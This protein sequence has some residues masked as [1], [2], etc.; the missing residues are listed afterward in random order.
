VS[1]LIAVLVASFFPIGFF[2]GALSHLLLKLFFGA[3]FRH[4]SEVHLEEDAL[5]RI[6]LLLGVEG[7]SNRAWEYYASA[8]F[9]HGIIAQREPGVHEWIARYWSGFQM[10]SHSAVALWLAHIAACI[11]NSQEGF[12]RSHYIRQSCG[13]WWLTLFMSSILITNAVISWVRCTRM[14]EFQSSRPEY[15]NPRP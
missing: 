10:S 2:I 9:D 15:R 1:G 7:T 3:V 5:R 6:W 11:L 14:I 12:A 4:W 13:W 8:S